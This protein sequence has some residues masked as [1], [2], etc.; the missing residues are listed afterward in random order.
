M[1]LRH[2]PNRARDCAIEMSVMGNVQRLDLRKVTNGVWEGALQFQIFQGYGQHVE[3]WHWRTANALPVV[4]AWVRISIK[5]PWNPVR[6]IAPF[7]IRAI[8]C[9]VKSGQG[10]EFR[11]RD[12]LR[13]GT[14]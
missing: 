6:N 3:R 12:V 9:I 5:Q 8:G 11:G 4:S 10:G 1:Q 14:K 13:R 2:V 7:P